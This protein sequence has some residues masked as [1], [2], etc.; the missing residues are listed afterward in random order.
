MRL[1]ALVAIMALDLAGGRQDPPAKPPRPAD[2]LP[3]ARLKA[4]AVIAAALTSG[5]A[6][7]KD[8]LWFGTPAGLGRVDAATNALTSIAVD[9]PPCGGL[10]ADG[11]V[12]W[13]PRCGAT[14]ALT[15]VDTATKATTT[16]ALRPVDASGFLAAAVGSVWVATETGGVVARVDPDTRD[17]VGEVYVAREPSSVAGGDE[18]LWITSVVGNTLTRVE[19]HTNAVVETVKVGPRPGRLAVTPDAVWVLNRGDDSV[20]RVDPK[21]N[22]VVATI[23]VGHGVGGGDI[24]AGEGAVFLSA[25]GSPLVRIDPESNRATHR[26]TGDGGGAVA[27]AHGS[28]WVADGPASTRRLD[29]RLVAAMRP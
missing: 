29:P 26:F 6:A 24:A 3:F 8:A 16:A 1:L 5:A 19:P 12:V 4:D 28:V 25:A 21:T 22:K 20:T 15:R 14:P 2:E 11:A 23:A 7:T 27:V 18:A 13:T 10:A 17:V 9:G